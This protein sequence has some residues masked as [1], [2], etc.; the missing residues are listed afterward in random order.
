MCHLPDELLVPGRGYEIPGYGLLPF[1]HN[2]FADGTIIAF[3]IEPDRPMIGTIEYGWTPGSADG[4]MTLDELRESVRRIIGV[5]VPIEAPKGPGPHA[6]RRLDGIN[7]RLADR[8]R[9]GRVLLLGDAAHVHS[10]MG[11]PGLNL[12]MQDAVNLGWKL[13]AAVTGR[14]P[15]RSARHLRVRALSGGGARDDALSGAAGAG[16][17]RTRSRGAANAFRRTG[18]SSRR[19]RS[20]WRACWLAPT[21]ATTSATAHRLSRPDGARSRPRRRP[22]R[23]RAAARRAP[24]ADRRDRWRGVAVARPGRIGW[25]S[26]PR[27][28]P[29]A[30]QPC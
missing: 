4:P 16:R 6:L 10:P 19:S 7:S 13:A 24:G 1:G 27:A 18:A 30:P 11:G 21:S 3:P 14:A 29:T 17:S 9:A 26:S 28:Y 25:T 5:D 23:R 2:R 12:G 22:T 15:E 20:T 8:Y